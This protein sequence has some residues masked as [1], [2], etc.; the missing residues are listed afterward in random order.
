MGERRVHYG[1]Q[2]AECDSSFTKPLNVSPPPAI[3]K[4]ED[5]PGGA[6]LLP[7][8]LRVDT[9]ECGVVGGKPYV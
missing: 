5:C 8:L 6:G 2:E 7:R 1:G 9:V 3:M 4:T